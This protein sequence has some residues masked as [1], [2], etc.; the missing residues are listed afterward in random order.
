MAEREARG[1]SGR[2]LIIE[3][4]ALI[5]LDLQELLERRG[6]GPV[7]IAHTAQAAE[8]RAQQ[9]FD[10]AI[11]DIKLAS[12]TSMVAAQA[13]HGNGTPLVFTT[14]YDGALPPPFASMP[15]LSKPFD[16]DRLDEAL[17]SALK[18]R[19]PAR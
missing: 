11:V 17:D 18:N 10:I 14:G 1:F 12:G 16:E 15:S 13:L 3:D 19:S 4:D 8:Q 7:E 5:A 9:R 6:F 2:A